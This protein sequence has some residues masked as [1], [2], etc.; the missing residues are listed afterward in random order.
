MARR[1]HIAAP[2]IRD[3]VYAGSNVINYS[4]DKVRQALTVGLATLMGGAAG[5]LLGTNVTS[6]GLAAQNEAIN[7]ATS[8]GPA[9]GIAAR[10]NAD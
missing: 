5:A 9:R 3:E 1:V 6:A 4:D 2:L 8:T 10:E 7:N